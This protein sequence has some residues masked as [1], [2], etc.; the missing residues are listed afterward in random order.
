MFAVCVFFLMIRRPPRSTRT[1]TLFPYTT[2]FRSGC[3]VGRGGLDGP[4]VALAGLPSQG[5]DGLAG[6]APARGCEQDD[7]GQH[8]Q[9]GDGDEEGGGGL[10]VRLPHSSTKSP[11]FH[12]K[13]KLKPGPRKNVQIMTSTAQYVRNIVNKIGRAQV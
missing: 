4:A 13:M 7:A 11:V 3:V 9:D 2:L 8:H 12:G 5:A 10:H 1:D 6:V